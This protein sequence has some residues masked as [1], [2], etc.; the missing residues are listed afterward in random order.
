MVLQVW[1]FILRFDWASGWLGPKLF[2]DKSGVSD[3]DMDEDISISK[4]DASS[5]EMTNVSVRYEHVT[6]TPKFK[7][8][9]VSVVLDF[10]TGC[11]RGTASDFGLNRQITVDQSSQGKYSLS[12]GSIGYLYI[13]FFLNR[14]EL[15]AQRLKDMRW[16]GSAPGGMM[17]GLRQ[18]VA[19]RVIM[20]TEQVWRRVLGLNSYLEVPTLGICH[21]LGFLF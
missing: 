12:L 4:G 6:T 20:H 10:P 7:R 8:R 18:E 19:Y 3:G 2:R 14:D 5:K 15:K 9:K 13:C 11:E 17:P 1:V 16:C 21:G